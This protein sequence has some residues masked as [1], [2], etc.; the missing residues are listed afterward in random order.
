MAPLFGDR[1]CRVEKLSPAYRGMTNPPK[2]KWAA[3][4]G[5]KS[6]QEAR[7][8]IDNNR[9]AE[10]NKLR[11]SQRSQYRIRILKNPIHEI[12]WWD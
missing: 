3:V 4:S 7:E 11:K 5:I 8:Y 1:C 12:R 9:Y 10:I 2:N 6:M